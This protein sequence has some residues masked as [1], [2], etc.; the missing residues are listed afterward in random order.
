[1]NEFM[2][3]TEFVKR[4]YLILIG[5]GEDRRDDKKVL[6]SIVKKVKA[7]SILVIPSASSYPR[8]V[9]D[10][11]YYAFK[12]LGVKEIE[13]LDIRYSDEADKDENFEKLAKADL[14]FFG[15]GDQV[16]LVEVLDSTNLLG[17]IKKR[18]YSGTLHIAGTSA[19]AAAA[20][21]P[22]LYDG[23]YRGFQKNSINSSSGFG[24]IND[25]AIDTHFLNR[26]RIPRLLQ[27]VL[28]GQSL[29]GMG[30]DEDTAVIISPD[31]RMEVVGTGM[32]TILNVNKITY[33]NYSYIEE[34]DN[35]STNNVRL[36]FLAP[37]TVFSIKRWSVLRSKKEKKIVDSK[38]VS[39]VFATIKS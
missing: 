10:T 29:R 36:G 33:S 9:Y 18:F 32:V 11:Y 31:L 25:I 5:G 4:S 8:D 3:K 34:G 38:N 21:N 15:G 30:I 28:A 26:E 23:D 24:F 6:K 27:F 17:E 20:A 7:K 35:Y 16:K 19:G 2:F 1:M 12:D 37:G 39:K 22:M 14:L 13:M